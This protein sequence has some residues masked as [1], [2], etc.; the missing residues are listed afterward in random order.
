MKNSLALGSSC[1]LF[2]TQNYSTVLADQVSPPH[3]Y[4]DTL[5]TAK[6]LELN[7]L[8]DGG[9]EKAQ[10]INYFKIKL[11]KVGSLTVESFGGTDTKANLLDSLG[12]TLATADTGG[13]AKNFKLSYQATAGIYY[14]AVK[15]AK[16][17]GIGT[18]Q[19]KASLQTATTNSNLIFPFT[20][21]QTWTVCQGYNTPEI[22]HIGPLNYSL[23][24]SIA[25]DATNTGGYGC[26]GSANAST[27]QNVLAPQAGTVA[28]ISPFTSDIIC[29]S[30]NTPA[31]NGAKS[32]LLGHF[33]P[34][35]TLARGSSIKQGDILGLVNPPSSKNGQYAHIHIS[36]HTTT[37]CLS[38][39]TLVAASL[40]LGQ[41]FGTQY[42]FTSDGS[43]HQWYGSKLSQ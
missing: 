43:K 30:L 24:F 4:T 6:A 8:V 25:K 26:I 5:K 19:V 39:G 11:K 13:S 10:D 7:K 17:A 42:N 3:E 18:Y 28:W 35:T 16:A 31:P 33:T 15:H 38:S 27:G 41:S 36:T 32:V 9:L 23:D 34:L 20:T 22:T 37:D 1:I 40:P 12:T 2:L 14:L 29:L 21:G